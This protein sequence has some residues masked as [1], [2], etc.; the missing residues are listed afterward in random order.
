L[1]QIVVICTFLFSSCLT[2]N[3]LSS[4]DVIS[5]AI[6]AGCSTSQQSTDNRI[7]IDCSNRPMNNKFLFTSDHLFTTT[8]DEIGS[9][10]TDDRTTIVSLNMRNTGIDTIPPLASLGLSHLEYLDVA[11]NNLRV[12]T[13]ASFEGLTSLQYLDLQYNPVFAVPRQ[14]LVSLISLKTLKIDSCIPQAVLLANGDTTSSSMTSSLLN[15]T[16][17]SIHAITDCQLESH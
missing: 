7:A 9:S 16:S 12:V 2:V 8:S 17:L 1:K 15:V 6:A 4:S 11:Q 10:N 14:L 5:A 3:S 13:N